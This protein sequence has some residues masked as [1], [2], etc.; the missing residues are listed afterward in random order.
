MHGWVWGYLCDLSVLNRLEFWSRRR[1]HHKK[2][3][4]NVCEEL[5]QVDVRVRSGKTCEVLSPLLHRCRRGQDL[6]VVAIV[7]VL[8]FVFSSPPPLHSLPT[9]LCVLLAMAIRLDETLV[10]GEGE[11]QVDS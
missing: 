3:V 8:L 11:Q 10:R 9:T 1:Y 4:L 2:Y 5:M 7:S 6:G